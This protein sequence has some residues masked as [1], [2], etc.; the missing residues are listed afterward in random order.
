VLQTA[1]AGVTIEGV[2]AELRA[3]PLR[4]SSEDRRWHGVA[5]DEYGGYSIE[6]M[7]ADPRDH[8]VVSMCMGGSPFVAQERA[9]QRHESAARAG[10]ATIIPAGLATRWQGFLPAHLCMRVDPATLHEVADA[11]RASGLHGVALANGFRVVD[12]VLQH[13]AA[14]FSAELGRADHPTQQLFMDSL[15]T[16]LTVHLLR[17]YPAQGAF[18]PLS[19]ATTMA[20]IR[21]AF[22]WVAE[23][24]HR[25]IRLDE[26]AQAAGLSRFHFSRLFKAH[27]GMTPAAYVERARIERA[28]AMIRSAEF[29]IAEVALAVGFADQSHFTRRFRRHAGQTPAAYA[30]E[31]ARGRLPPPVRH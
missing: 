8:P 13:I 31:Y 21:R 16:T 4:A 6:E 24:P 17:T 1:P 7:I 27:V 14:M 9:G 12:P 15:A 25:A 18:E 30:R 19:A 3:R 20:A 11:M 10:E 26:M 5:L 29:S 22:D 28:K 2:R 23:N